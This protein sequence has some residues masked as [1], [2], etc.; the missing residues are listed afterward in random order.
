MTEGLAKI[1]IRS[2]EI[3]LFLF[4]GLFLAG[5]G[6]GLLHWSL[7]DP[8]GLSALFLWRCVT[9]IA[10][11]LVLA[12]GSGS[13][14]LK[15]STFR[16]PLSMLSTSG[17]P[18]DSLALTNGFEVGGEQG[19]LGSEADL[20][21]TIVIRLVGTLLCVLGA[22]G[23]VLAAIPTPSFCDFPENCE[24]PPPWA[25][26]LVGLAGSMILA[27]GVVILLRTRRKS[28]RPLSILESSR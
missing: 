22:G 17:K 25:V 1:L 10:A 7:G 9:C 5:G 23:V 16:G 11:G 27:G 14:L 20:L 3:V 21:L 26:A 2:L 12:A 18:L 13:L 28:H 19:G 24:P 4:G 8:P 15:T 6:V